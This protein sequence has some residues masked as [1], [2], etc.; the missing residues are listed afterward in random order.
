MRNTSTEKRR[1]GA[2]MKQSLVNHMSLKNVK[3]NPKLPKTFQVDLLATQL[4]YTEIITYER[5]IVPQKTINSLSHSFLEFRLQLLGWG[6]GSEGVYVFA[7]QTC[8]A[9]MAP[10]A[11][12]GP[13]W[14][15]P[16]G[17]CG[18]WNN[19]GAEMVFYLFQICLPQN[20]RLF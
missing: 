18:C 5:N 7:L 15:T 1:E 4:S 6:W 3:E 14:G 13:S 2:H 17:L 20:G 12:S 16:F 19:F 8:F 9:Q 11:Y 10:T